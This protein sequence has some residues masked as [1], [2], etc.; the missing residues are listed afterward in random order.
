M[1]KKDIR[2]SDAIPQRPA[3]FDDAVEQTLARVSKKEQQKETPV[4]AW[5]VENGKERKRRSGRSVFDIVGIA[6]IFVVCI[7]AI[8]TVIGVRA[9][10]NRT[11]PA[12][13]AEQQTAHISTE[14]T[15]YVSTVDEL[16]A[17][18]APDTQVI[19]ADGTYNLT[20]ASDYGTAGNQYYTWEDRSDN[21]FRSPE[22]NSF[23]LSLKDLEDFCIIGSK[24]AQ[25]VTV[26]RTAAVISAR[27]CAGLV[28]SGFT[29]GHTVMADPCEGEVI[30]LVECTDAWVENC[31]LYGCGTVGVNAV[32]CDNLVVTGS[33]IYE[34]SY[35]GV[36]F[37]R[38]RD[39]LLS[40][41]TLRNCG[42]RDEAFSMVCVFDCKNLRITACDIYENRTET[43]FNLVDDENESGAANV[44]ILGT[45]VRDN[46]I[47]EWGFY[48][49]TET[50]P[51][52]A[53]C[54]FK[55]N[56][57]VLLSDE[58]SVYDRSGK[59]LKE[60]DLLVMQLDRTLNIEPAVLPTPEPETP[61]ARVPAIQV[62]G[63]MY[64]ITEFEAVGEPD[65][66]AIGY[67]SSVVPLSEWPTEDGQANFGEVGTPYALTADGLFVLYG[68]EWR[69]FEAE[70]F[71]GDEPTPEP[72]IDPVSETLCMF[73][74]G[75]LYYEPFENWIWS[76]QDDGLAA[77]GMTFL[78]KMEEVKDK[79]PTIYNPGKL[80]VTAGDG[81]HLEPKVNIYDA[82]L[83]TVAF[84]AD[85]STVCTLDPG[86]YYVSQRVSHREEGKTS[87]Y[88][89]VVCVEIGTNETQP[90]PEPQTPEPA[91]MIPSVR[92]NGTVYRLTDEPYE[93]ETI[94]MLGAIVETEASPIPN[95]DNHAN[96]GEPGMTL[97]LTKD[98]LVIFDRG[99]CKRLEPMLAQRD[100][101]AVA[102]MMVPAIRYQ[103]ILYLIADGE[104]ARQLST[105][106]EYITYS[107]ASSVPPT[108]WPAEEEQI[109]FDW[110]GARV[111]ET[112]DGL[113]VEKDG[114]MLLFRP[115]YDIS[116]V[117]RINGD[118]MV[119]NW[120]FLSSPEGDGMPIAWVL[121]HDENGDIYRNTPLMEYKGQTIDVVPR[122]WALERIYLLNAENE[123]IAEMTV[124]ELERM[125]ACYE[126][127]YSFFEPI[128]PGTYTLSAVMTLTDGSTVTSYEC[129]IRFSNGE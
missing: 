125:E 56:D 38:C 116:A 103:G 63:E 106:G 11:A 32:D 23:E 60:A 75:C 21:W 5:K 97:A 59:R 66:S 47:I 54:E 37:V 117:F 100:G 14:H 51:V 18:I 96:F 94:Q 57:G 41:C 83:N 12:A 127:P 9:H 33:D 74:D 73:F 108:E 112:R 64:V 1:E 113:I 62:N 10:L 67:V 71:G 99:S 35:G 2:V 118:Y 55:N 40:G 17:A 68:S 46:T 85:I 61:N 22:E 84:G 76:D 42:Y 4:R 88:E 124:D 20:E 53:G 15:V 13:E 8:G 95:A 50:G 30:R 52:V 90:T 29:A 19:L 58:V 82:A 49:N 80:T 65:E 24:D 98:G 101:L 43:V 91:A 102:G 16:L 107:I 119:P 115:T 89:C 48:S 109:N 121:A 104:D 129:F 105:T 81:V 25:I 7:A 123:Q 77:D 87:G 36:L 128:E 110:L 44:S 120:N 86:T 92:Y 27:N 45:S 78:W 3:S 39:T 6:A 34:C 26:P 31:S 69:L 114:E 126:I 111:S 122:G 72:A 79:I 70:E 93:G 28:L